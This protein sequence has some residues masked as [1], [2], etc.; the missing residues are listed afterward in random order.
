MRRPAVAS[1]AS[2]QRPALGDRRSAVA[3]GGRRPD[4]GPR[5]TLRR[6]RPEK[7]RARRSAAGA[8]TG[9][10]SL[11]LASGTGIGARCPARDNPVRDERC[12]SRCPVGWAIDAGLATRGAGP[13]ARPG[14]AGAG[15]CRGEADVGR[16]RRHSALQSQAGRVPAPGGGAAVPANHRR[17]P[18]EQT[19]PAPGISVS[20]ETARPPFHVKPCGR[21]AS[22]TA[23]PRRRPC[24]RP[25]PPAGRQRASG[26][27][28]SSAR[29][30]PGAAAS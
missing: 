28:L 19:G 5:P 25:Q 23:T 6:R 1:V 18:A 8:R 30:A 22:A 17:V 16:I 29:R 27:A 10:Q 4:R 2:A 3:V 20:R 14:R 7:V 24:R 9:G 21:T 26:A 11:V 12:P 13:L 15:R